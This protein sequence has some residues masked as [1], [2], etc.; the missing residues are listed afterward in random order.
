[1]N[2]TVFEEMFK[3]GQDVLVIAE[4]RGHEFNIGEIVTLTE[5]DNWDNGFYAKG[6]DGYEWWVYEGEI[7]PA[8]K[9]LSLIHI[10]KM[11]QNKELEVGQEV[12][13]V[14]E[15]NEYNTITFTVGE[16]H[17]GLTLNEPYGVFTDGDTIQLKSCLYEP[18]TTF[19]ILQ[20][21]VVEV[22]EA[23]ECGCCA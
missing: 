13:V 6:K 21:E 12:K 19:E 1:M 3:V 23:C 4:E 11:L 16:D 18:E 10:I 15:N 17:F 8:T 20:K 2:K 7:A 9:G 14:F 5:F 22:A